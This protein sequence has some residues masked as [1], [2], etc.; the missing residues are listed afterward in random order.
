MGLRLFSFVAWRHKWKKKHED[1]AIVNKYP[2]T[3][4]FSTISI[5]LCVYHIFFSH[6]AL[7]YPRTVIG[8]RVSSCT[9]TTG[10]YTCSVKEFEKSWFHLLWPFCIYK[11]PLLLYGLGKKTM[12]FI[13]CSQVPDNRSWSHSRVPQTHL[14]DVCHA[15]QRTKL[16]SVCTQRRVRNE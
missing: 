11:I 7:R 10:L 16:A 8:H 6:F 4:S 15:N 9:E 14:S 12:Y 5:Y 3:P 1:L 2:K 13:H